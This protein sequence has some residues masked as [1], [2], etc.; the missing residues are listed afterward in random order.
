MCTL[1]MSSSLTVLCDLL[2]SAGLTGPGAQLRYQFEPLPGQ[3]PYQHSMQMDSVLFPQALPE[4]QV[5][6]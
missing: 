1:H 6:K 4:N 2:E 5:A 3:E